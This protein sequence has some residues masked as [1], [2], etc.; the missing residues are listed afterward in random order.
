MAASETQIANLAMGKIGQARIEALT[1]ESEPARWAAEYFG[2]ARDYV[3]EAG[4]WRHAKKTMYLAQ[5]DN[6]RED[7]Y[8]YAYERPSDCLKLW[9]L[10]PQLGGFD[11]RNP[12]RY[13]TEGDV[14]Y[15]D[16]QIARGVYV[17]QITDVTKFMPSFTEAMAWYLAHLC[18][19]PLRLENSL[20]GT[21]LS[22]YAGAFQHAVATGAV[23]QLLIWDAN[24]A[25]P[26]WLAGR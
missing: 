23:E 17:R 6:D 15:T 1:E 8:E 7:D 11:P 4:I 20:I 24:E 10:L 26:D 18:V 5:V 3:T 19:T 22:G 13:E 14:I 21:T 12:I 9:Y 16:E 2:Q 25:Q